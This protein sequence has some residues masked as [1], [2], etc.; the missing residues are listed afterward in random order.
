ME[1]GCHRLSKTQQHAGILLKKWKYVLN[2]QSWDNWVKR[3]NW[4][5]TESW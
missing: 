5:V 3:Q 2:V 1:L 4:A